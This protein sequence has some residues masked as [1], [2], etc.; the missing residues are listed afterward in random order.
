VSP[1]S[2]VV[3]LAGYKCISTPSSIHHSSRKY[4]LFRRPL[5]PTSS[6][7][8]VPLTV[9]RYLF[10]CT[11]RPT[12]LRASIYICFSPTL[13]IFGSHLSRLRQKWIIIIFILSD[14]TSLLLQAGGGAI[15]V[16]A[17]S[18]MVEEIGIHLMIAG[19]ALQVFSIFVI[20]LIAADF[21]W[22][23]ARKRGIW[24]GRE[25]TSRA[26]FMGFLS[27]QLQSSS[28]LASESLSLLAAFLGSYGIVRSPSW[29]SVG[30]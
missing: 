28:A 20:L 25:G 1:W 15:S 9:D 17:D 26:F 30:L 23:C 21:A 2:Y 7:L 3:T 11:I 16:I 12:F 5:I 14:F 27:L 8:P 19:L 24:I 4:I 6:S 10:P 22:T 29:C 13:S 18:F